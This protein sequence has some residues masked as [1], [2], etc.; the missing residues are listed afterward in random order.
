MVYFNYYR[1]VSVYMLETLLWVFVK[2]CVYYH[3]LPMM[4]YKA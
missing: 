2:H 1:V 4:F 3:T